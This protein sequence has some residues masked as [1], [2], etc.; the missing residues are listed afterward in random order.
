MLDTI[1][2]PTGTYKGTAELPDKERTS[3]YEK[4]VLLVSLILLLSI[5]VVA[6]W[7]AI[8]LLFGA[9]DGGGPLGVFMK[10][11]SAY[12]FGVE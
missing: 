8:L 10:P 5:A 12:L 7:S 3:R 1:T 6:A 2:R 4:M 11:L 9:V